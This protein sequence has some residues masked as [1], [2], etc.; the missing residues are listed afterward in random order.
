MDEA[1]QLQGMISKTFTELK[2]DN[3][4]C[5]LPGAKIDFMQRSSIR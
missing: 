4:F 5:T 1:D 2:T 3:R